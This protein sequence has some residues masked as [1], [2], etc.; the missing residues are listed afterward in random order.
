MIDVTNSANVH[1]RFF[2]EE[3]LRVPAAGHAQCRE[4]GRVGGSL[5]ELWG[6]EGRGGGRVEGEME[7]N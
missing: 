3:S 7:M 5:L 2:T 6:G 1:V 4:K